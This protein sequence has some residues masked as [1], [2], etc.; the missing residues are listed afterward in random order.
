MTEQTIDDPG[1]G[2]SVHVSVRIDR[3]PQDV[4]AYAADPA[5]LPH[6]A[7]G[8]AQSALRPDGDRWIADSPMGEVSVRFAPANDFGVLDHWVTLPDGETVHNP[9]RVLPDGDG[10]EVIFTIRRRSMTDEQFAADQDAVRT[11]LRSL[12]SILQRGAD[13]AAAG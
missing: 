3:A 10:S 12:R 9:M 6:W 11:D 13:P 1:D 4:Y 7:A 2:G 5:N 8:L